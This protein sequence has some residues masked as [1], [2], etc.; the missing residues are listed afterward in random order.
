VAL[1]V[2][3][4]TG[5]APAQAAVIFSD[6]FEAGISGWTGAGGVVWRSGPPSNGAYC[7]EL[8]RTASIQQTIPTVPYQ[9]IAV[10]FYLGAGGLEPGESVRALWYDGASWTVLAAINR[11][12]PEEDGALHYYQFALPPG[13]VDNP[14]FALRFDINANNPN[15]RGFV[16]DV[17]VSG[18]LIFYTLGLA[19]VGG[20]SVRVDGVLQSLPWSG[21]F[22]SGSTVTLE[23]APD[24][25]WQF[26][27]WSG[28][29]TGSTS[30][31]TITMDA[32][33]S[34]T[35]TFSIIM[36][37]LSL[38]GVGN[39]SVRVNGVL[40][41]LPWSGSFASSSTVNL[42][43]VP[44]SGWQF[45]NWS[46]DLTG[47]TS[48]TTI[49]MNAGKSVTAN[50]SQIYTLSL[51]KT[52]NGSVRVDGVLR[53]LPWSATFP[54]GTS[55]TLDAVPDSGW[56]FDNWT[57]DYNWAGT[58]I[59]VTMD[60]DKSIAA[61]FTAQPTLSITST[62][63][64]TVE[65]DGI[66]R[67]LPWSAQFD[68]GTT[69]ALEAIPDA[70]YSFDGWSGDR[71]WGD[72]VMTTAIDEDTSIVA[73]FVPT[74]QS[75]LTLQGSGEG[76]VTVDGVLR[77]LPWSGQFDT[78][79]TV[80][81]EAVPAPGW[82]FDG[83]TGDI[84]W[85]SSTVSVTMDADKTV[86]ANFVEA[87]GYTLTVSKTGTGSVVVDGTTRSLPWSGE[88]APGATV[89]LEAVPGA[90]WEFAEWS[91]DV[92][93]SDNPL[94]LTLNANTDIT[95][96]FERITYTL[97]LNLDG[98]GSVIVN[99]STWT[100]P[101]TETVAHGTIVELEAV[102]DYGW[103]FTGWS[104]DLSGTQNPVAFVMNGD[105]TVTAEFVLPDSYFLTVRKTG[106]GSVL[107]DGELALLPWTAEIP[108]GAEVTL[109]VLTEEDEEFVAWSGDLT[110]T[111]T[112]ATVLMDADKA[113]T[114]HFGCVATF[115]D[116]QCEYW[117]FDEIE[118]ACQTSA[119]HGYPDG[120]YR[121][122]LSIDRAQM[123]V[124]DARA[125][126]GGRIPTGTAE[127]TF[128]DVP[129]DHW[130]FHEIEYVV[131]SAVVAGYPDGNY[132]PDWTL[133]RGQMAVFIARSICTPTGE[134]GLADYVPPDSPTFD[135]VPT[136]YW[137]YSHIE[138]LVERNVVRGYP[139]GRYRPAQT[140]TR[141][142]MAVY[143]CQA[144]RLWE[145]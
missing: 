50:F 89:T 96:T 145:P 14:A 53:S 136:W 30:P 71:S 3:L 134:A 115:P 55:V 120:L 62:G 36:Y 19:G 38:S 99:G 54:P 37:A 74:P 49:T 102:P 70:G 98:S 24:S 39:G 45:D 143:I 140:V 94:V 125:M 107:V 116:V 131:D 33:K 133:T 79:A 15:D 139:D 97:S 22:P 114:A 127:A 29:L 27:S 113:V 128:P 47:S 51:T 123:A 28:D 5:A 34:V 104:G 48:P 106:A 80:A 86:V 60:S 122:E 18:D 92:A 26:D 66:P 78:G 12:D 7:V 11:G 83:W 67:A 103:R 129:A 137:S 17:Q 4:L 91:G 124:Y 144:F 119:V 46:G 135:D 64:G 68:A 57:G 109:E 35:A 69:V 21:S 141:G 63:S 9:N 93:S 20:G 138:Y 43:A 75:T 88:F 130:A 23:A 61:N 73:N 81:L 42:E 59:T 31:T 132:H 58:P 13:A 16:D 90:G 56:E 118:L 111:D 72:P 85:S 2:L 112:I 101:G 10:S 44:D 77:S 142:Q 25:G 82:A 100:S 65:V 76:S 87:A 84:N 95:A 126:S 6:N 41:A 32:D 40:R 105:K 1:A 8:S 117:C 52:G 121:P 110:G 108:S